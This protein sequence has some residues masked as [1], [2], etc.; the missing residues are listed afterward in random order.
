MEKPH[1]T[2]VNLINVKD[3]VSP[4]TITSWDKD[5]IAKPWREVASK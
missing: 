2:E 3:F 5:V 1:L 4:Y